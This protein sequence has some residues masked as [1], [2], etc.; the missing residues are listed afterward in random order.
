M[1]TIHVL[2]ALT[3]ALSPL[4]ASAQ[5]IGNIEG[6]LSGGGSNDANFEGDLFWLEL[7]IDIGYYPTFGLLFGF[8]NEPAPWEVDFSRYPYDDGRNGLYQPLDF[9]GWR[10]RTQVLSHFQSNEDALYG[11]FFQV[12]FYPTPWLNLDVNRLQLLETL[13]NG[14]DHFSITNF[15]FQYSRIRHPRFHLWWGVGLML[16]DGEFLYGSASV[17]TGFTWYF[18][19]PLSLHAETQ[20]GFPNDVIARQHTARI[21]AHLGRYLIFAGYQG[22]RAGDVRQPNWAMGGGVWF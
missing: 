13:D 7:L 15:N 18:K 20:I 3:L 9:D 2:F 1:K 14:T 5:I 4:S 17:S 12:K 22:L 16:L 21:Q 6:Q 10:V 11:G 8:D 19:K